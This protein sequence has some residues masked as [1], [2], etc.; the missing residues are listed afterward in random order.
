MAP[1][2]VEIEAPGQ[3]LGPAKPPPSPLPTTTPDDSK[4]LPRAYI[5]ET[6]QDVL[7]LFEVPEAWNAGTS[8][9]REPYEDTT[10][11]DSKTQPR[12]FI[13]DT[14][15]HVE[16]S[17]EQ[18][19]DLFY[20]PATS[21]KGMGLTRESYEDTTPIDPKDPDDPEIQ[22]RD[23]IS[24]ALQPFEDGFEDFGDL[25]EQP[26]TSN[27]GMG[28]T[29]ESYE[30]MS[31]G[32][33]KIDPDLTGTEATIDGMTYEDITPDD[34]E[35]LPRSSRNDIT[36]DIKPIIE[37]IVNF[38]DMFEQPA[39]SNEGMGL[40]VES[41][42]D[43]SLGT[44]EINPD[45]IGIETTIDGMT[46]EDIQYD[47]R[48]IRPR[49][50]NLTSNSTLTD[51]EIEAAV[52]AAA[53]SPEGIITNL[54]GG[55]ALTPDKSGDPA[56]TDEEIAAAVNADS[57]D[58]VIKK[59]EEDLGVSPDSSDAP[60]EDLDIVSVIPILPGDV[61]ENATDP[62][63]PSVEFDPAKEITEGARKVWDDFAHWLTKPGNICLI[64]AIA[65]TPLFMC[66]VFSG[67]KHMGRKLGWKWAKEM[68][69][70]DNVDPCDNNSS[71]PRDPIPLVAFTPG[72]SQANPVYLARRDYDAY[73][74]DGHL[75]DGLTLPNDRRDSFYVDNNAP[76]SGPPSAH[77][78]PPRTFASNT[79]PQ[80]PP[81][82]HEE[83]EEK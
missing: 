61:P 31:L 5:P 48:K 24:D 17:V 63:T 56:V 52:D 51:A 72:S 3:G 34:S 83:K 38:G 82:Y 70:E 21:N 9:T 50:S 28:L 73:W 41:Y 46:Y 29:V 49:S 68:D 54:E 45:L 7:D 18:L 16:E 37:A 47:S 76:P 67:L 80:L 39:T 25:F 71:S 1:L 66:I 23:F 43:A 8:L 77:R 2:P 79:S 74:N 30:D 55:V 58:A 75:Y 59:L 64:A 44:D 62:T 33:D 4:I 65:M 69:V 15:Q 78:A 57:P 13:T 40:T 27:K 6:Y 14:I 60:G 53:A 10:R 35:I 20:Q 19:E 32:N 11:D 12:G 26:A 81:A 36:Y 42:E 22:P